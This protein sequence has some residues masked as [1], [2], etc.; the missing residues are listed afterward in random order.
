MGSV[1]V[2]R[3]VKVDGYT[4]QD[5]GLYDRDDAEN[6]ARG[7]NN[8]F[9]SIASENDRDETKRL[10]LQTMGEFAEY[11]AADSEPRWF[12]DYLLGRVF[13]SYSGPVTGRDIGRE[14]E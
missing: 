5:W 6:L 4:A 2:V 1:S 10:M 14:G 3:V 13:G 9:S 12:L 7:L 8:A 11:G